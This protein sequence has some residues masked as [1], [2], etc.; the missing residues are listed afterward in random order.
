[1]GHFKFNHV[2]REMGRKNDGV[3]FSKIQNFARRKMGRKTF[4]E[5][6]F[7]KFKT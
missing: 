5:A 6:K 7:H 4:Q 1:M 2:R 3:F